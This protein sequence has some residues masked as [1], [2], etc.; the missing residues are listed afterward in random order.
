MGLAMK[1]PDKSADNPAYFYHP[2]ISIGPTQAVDGGFEYRRRIVSSIRSYTRRAID[3]LIGAGRFEIS[4]QQAMSMLTD[5]TCILSNANCI[6]RSPLYSWQSP[7]A[8]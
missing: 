1:P 2:S 7:P 3:N 4:R 8:G 6:Y 5:A